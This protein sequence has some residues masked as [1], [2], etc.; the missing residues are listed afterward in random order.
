MT[1][2]DLLRETLDVDCDEVWEN[3]RTPTPVRVSG[4]RLHSMGLSVREVPPYWDY[5]ALIDLTGRSG[6]GRMISP[7]PRVTRR[8]RR[9]R[10]LP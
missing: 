9:R 7:T 4:V 3:E 1:L 10:E 8:R 2:A 6:T 5:S